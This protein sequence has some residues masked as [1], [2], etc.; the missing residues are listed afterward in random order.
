M[1]PD[2]T[3]IRKQL[4]KQLAARKHEKPIWCHDDLAGDSI[5]F[6][7]TTCEATRVQ[8]DERPNQQGCMKGFIHCLW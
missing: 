2:A 6:V 5:C 1:H 7:Q 3:S 4:N 8:C